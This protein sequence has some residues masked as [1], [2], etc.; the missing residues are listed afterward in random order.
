M[1][2]G[3]T[4]RRALPPKTEIIRLSNSAEV[5]CYVV[6]LVGRCDWYLR[7]IHA[8]IRETDHHNENSILLNSSKPCGSSEG[9][10]SVALER[11]QDTAM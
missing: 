10:I 7:K 3:G 5:A 1:R 11:T 4:K 6:P 8:N 2:H 9:D